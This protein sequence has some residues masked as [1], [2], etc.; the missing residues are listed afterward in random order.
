[1]C[2]ALCNTPGGADEAGWRALRVLP[3]LLLLLL[4]LLA[5]PMLLL[6]LL[7]LLCCI[8]CGIL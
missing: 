8:G 5:L 6:V 4:L 2:A 1:V 7:L 3:L